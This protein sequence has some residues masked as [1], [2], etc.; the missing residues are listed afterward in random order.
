MK[1]LQLLVG[2]TFSDEISED[3]IKEIAENVLAGVVRHSQNIG[4]APLESYG[5]TEAVEVS[6]SGL[7]LASEDLKFS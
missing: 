3:Q 5:H 4:V 7:V 6:H 1:K 2:L